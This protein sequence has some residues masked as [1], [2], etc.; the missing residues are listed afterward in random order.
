MSFRKK[1][2]LGDNVPRNKLG[3][4]GDEV[5]YILPKF[6]CNFK[7]YKKDTKM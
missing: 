6:I 4:V 5:P 7:K 2:V 3:V 1:G